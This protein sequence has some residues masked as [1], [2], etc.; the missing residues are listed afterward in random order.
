METRSSKTT[1]NADTIVSLKAIDKREIKHLEYRAFRK[2]FWGNTKE[3]FYD[4]HS[5]NNLRYSK[6]QLESGGNCYDTKLIVENNKAYYKPYVK[7][8]FQ[9]E[10]SLVKVFNTY[11]EAL[12]FANEVSAK[13]IKNKLISVNDGRI[14]ILTRNE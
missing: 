7:I 12:N 9:T 13:C 8:N 11:I 5:M 4:I 2:S 14:E 3:G 6:E 1:Y 10:V